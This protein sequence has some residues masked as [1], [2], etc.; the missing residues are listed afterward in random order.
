MK[1]HPFK[2][3][4]QGARL[5]FLAEPGQILLDNLLEQSVLILARRGT[6]PGVHGEIHHHAMFFQILEKLLALV[7]RLSHQNQGIARRDFRLQ[8]GH[9]QLRPVRLG[10]GRGKIPL[11]RRACFRR[12]IQLLRLGKTE[13]LLP[14]AGRAGGDLLFLPIRWGKIGQGEHL[15]QIPQGFFHIFAAPSLARLVPQDTGHDLGKKNLGVRYPNHL[16]GAEQAVGFEHVDRGA[17]LFLVAVNDL[18]AVL[19]GGFIG[20][21]AADQ[22]VGDLLTEVALAEKQIDRGGFSAL[23]RLEQRIDFLSFVNRHP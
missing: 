5:Q 15:G 16:P 20:Q 2:E 9:E 1:P 4:R 22:I 11:A 6:P 17:H 10:R 21:Q 12:P 23:H 19:A 13:Q 8:S 18:Q 7:R 14:A 3:Y